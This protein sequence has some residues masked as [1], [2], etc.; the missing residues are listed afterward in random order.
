[1]AINRGFNRGF[2]RRVRYAPP[3]YMTRSLSSHPHWQSSRTCRHEHR[4]LAQQQLAPRASPVSTTTGATCTAHQHVTRGGVD[5][6]RG[7]VDVTRG[8]VDVT[9]G[10]MHVTRGGMHVTRGGVSAL[11]A[12][13]HEDVNC[14]RMA[15]GL[16]PREIPDTYYNKVVCDSGSWNMGHA[17]PSRCWVSIMWAVGSIYQRER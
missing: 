1:M 5:V 11:D 9:R 7:G 14:V 12:I 8:G 10:G 3:H 4:L 13:Y 17:P 6:T 16:V 2:N 15:H